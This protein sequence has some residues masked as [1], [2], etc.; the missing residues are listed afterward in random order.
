MGSGGTTVFEISGV[1]EGRCTFRAAYAQEWEFGG[2]ETMENSFDL[3][4]IPIRVSPFCD[5]TMDCVQ[6][7]YS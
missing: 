4:E 6:Y 2:F 3:L 5:T 1:S 7:G